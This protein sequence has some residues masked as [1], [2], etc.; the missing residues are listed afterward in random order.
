M[1][2]AFYIGKSPIE[3]S[4]PASRMASSFYAQR[5][6]EYVYDVTVTK[7]ETDRAHQAPHLLSIEFEKRTERAS[8]LP[9]PPT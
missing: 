9:K 6:G 2:H 3:C 5:K 7:D 4:I 1:T 8:A